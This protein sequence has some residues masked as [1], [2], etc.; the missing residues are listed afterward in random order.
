[1][2]LWEMFTVNI[3]NL[4]TGLEA[5]NVLVLWSRQIHHFPQV[6]RGCHT[7]SGSVLLTLFTSPARVS[8]RT[9]ALKCTLVRDPCAQAAVPAGLPCTWVW[10]LSG[11]RANL[12]KERIK[13]KQTK[14]KQTNINQL[15]TWERSEASANWHPALV[16]LLPSTCALTCF[17]F[18]D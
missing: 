3:S 6:H 1:M 5:G 17:F 13:T 18:Q 12:W 14:R 4:Q 7:D 11:D 16:I 2:V 10:L 15:W 8:L 9:G